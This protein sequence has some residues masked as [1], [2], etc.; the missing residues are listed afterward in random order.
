MV[1][2]NFRQPCRIVDPQ[3]SVLMSTACS[4]D[5]AFLQ[6]HCS[7]NRMKNPYGVNIRNNVYRAMY[8]HGA[9]MDST[10][11]ARRETP[12]GE[13]L[14]SLRKIYKHPLPIPI[15]NPSILSRVMYEIDVENPRAHLSYPQKNLPLP[16][17]GQVYKPIEP[18]TTAV[19][20]WAFR[21]KCL[22]PIPFRDPKLWSSP[23]SPPSP[24]P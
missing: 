11:L 3:S 21:H 6:E 2:A 14:R 1:P 12:C 4:A 23:S 8:F 19:C 7:A 9:H 5:C 18:A 17:Y 20:T 15:Q 24:H 22:C 10:I 13:I 16:Y